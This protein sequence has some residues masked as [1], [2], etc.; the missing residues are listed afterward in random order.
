LNQKHV[1]TENGW[2][3]AMDSARLLAGVKNLVAGFQFRRTAAALLEMVQDQ[4][5]CSVCDEALELA[6]RAAREAVSEDVLAE[7][8]AAVL[9]RLAVLPRS[10]PPAQYSANLAAAEALRPLP[11]D[12]AFVTTWAVTKSLARSEFARDGY[13]F[14]ALRQTKRRMASIVRDVLGN[15]FRPTNFEADWRTAGVEALASQMAAAGEFSQMP[16][17]AHALVEAGCA[18]PA[19]LAHCRGS[20][21][22]VRGCWVIDLILTK[23]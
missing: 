22:H 14:S 4:F 10:T 9:T 19:I 12:A 17:L 13:W 2:L 6:N 20:T 16:N 7:M 18:D 5:L 23:R 1:L 11:F 8:R 15:P 3:N 21:T